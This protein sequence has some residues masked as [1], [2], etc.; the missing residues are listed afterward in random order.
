VI[1][2]KIEQMRRDATENR[3]RTQA[4][5][6]IADMVSAKEGGTHHVSVVDK[7]GN[8]C[9]L[10]HTI[11]GPIYSSHG[12]FVGGIV[13]NSARGGRTGQPG[14]RMLT[15]LAPVIVFKGDKPYFATGSSGGTTNAFLTTLNVLVWDKNL[16]EAQEAPRFRFAPGSWSGPPG[17]DNKVF[18]EHRIDDKVAGPLK[19][20]GYQIEWVG[21]YSQFGA[22]MIGI[23][24]NSG[25]RYGATDPRLVGQAAGQ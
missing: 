9:S 21:P 22:Q 24:P 2:H 18:I 8:I 19:K 17:E 5:V 20:R 7:D 15:S 23:D 10:T 6:S 14:G 12:L 1:R 11:S 3:R 16:K 25:M 4:A 13:M